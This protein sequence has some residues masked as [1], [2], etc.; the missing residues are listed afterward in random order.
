[1]PDCRGV[2][3][4]RI[5]SKRAKKSPFAG[6]VPQS[7]I[8]A[9]G[10]KY[11]LSLQDRLTRNNIL[12]PLVGKTSSLII[13]GPLDHYLYI[14]GA[15]KTIL[16]DQGSNFLLELMQQFEEPLR[17]QHVKT[18]AIHP[19]SHI[20]R[21]H[22]ELYNLIKISE[23]HNEW[24]ENLK[25]ISFAIK[26]M[27]NQPTGLTPF[28]LMFERKPNILSTI[29]AS[30]TLT[31]QELIRKRKHKHEENLKKA[32]ERIEMEMEKTKR[33]LDE[34]IVR[35]HLLYKSNDLVKINNNTKQNRLKASWRGPYEVIDYLDNNNLSIRNKNK[36]IRSHVDQ[37]MPYFVDR[38]NAFNDDDGN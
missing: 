21:M 4:S 19:Q 24:D 23:R 5:Y 6:F 35:K 38:T 25:F 10:N 18:T 12:I 11:T 22:S 28:E 33:R 9:N 36:I 13:K 17:I 16:T 1:M 29:A 8:T 20:E 31:H 34:S 2:G 32:K 27:K 15:P 37:A 14:F 26:T 7:G 30:P 3:E